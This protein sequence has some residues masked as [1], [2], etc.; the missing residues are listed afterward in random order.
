MISSSPS[1]LQPVFQA[2]LKNAVRLCDAKFGNIYRWEG[3]AL[4]LVATQKYPPPSSR[5]VGAHRYV[6][7]RKLPPGA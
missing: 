1:D 2:M 6:Q 7:V 3:D 5:H 4:H